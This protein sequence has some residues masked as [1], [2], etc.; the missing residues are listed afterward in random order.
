MHIAEFLDYLAD[1]ILRNSIMP[2][3]PIIVKLV[4][5]GRTSSQSLIAS[6]T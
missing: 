3:M 6:T 2:C 1:P 5:Q 4:M